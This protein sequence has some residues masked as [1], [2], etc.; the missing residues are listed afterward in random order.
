ML[1][2]ATSP[3]PSPSPTLEGPAGDV[4]NLW[5]DLTSDTSGQFLGLGI[6]ILLLVIAWFVGRAVIRGIVLGIE[7]GTPLDGRARRAL[8]KAKIKVAEPDTMELRLEGERRRQ[9]AKTIGRVLNSTLLVIL[10]TIGVTTLLSMIGVPVAPLMASAGVV[11]VALGFGAQSLVKDVLS[12]VFMLLEDQYGVG[13]VVNLG[14][15]TGSVEEV[16][17]RCTRLRSLDGT[18]WYVPNGEI[19]RVGNMTRMW[20]RALVEV[21]FAY[22]TD[23]EAAREAM[24][25]AVKAAQDKHK[26]VAAAILG[27]AEVAGIESL[28][29]NAVMLR[30]LVQTNPAAQWDVQREVRHEMRRIFAERGIELAVPGEAMVVD[31]GSSRRPL[32]DSARPAGDEQPVDQD[33]RPLP[34]PND[35][36]DE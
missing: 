9:R 35:G 10:I 20:S 13:D 32:H 22:D 6:A 7:K 30:L 24:I 2:F 16:G 27:E 28:E 36:D 12:G 15:A 8:R 25:D 4:Q 31:A 11:G 5:E 19:T 29:Y 34:P 17:L 23:I 26:K 21:R 3:E 18:V 14:E 33:G 1:T